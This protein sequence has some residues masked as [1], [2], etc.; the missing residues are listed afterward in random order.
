MR[1]VAVQAEAERK[2]LLLSWRQALQRPTQLLMDGMLEHTSGRALIFIRWEDLRKAPVALVSYRRV[3]RKRIHHTLQ[4]VGQ[5]LFRHA[6]RVC[7]LTTA[8][9]APKRE[10]QL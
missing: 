8:G 3:Q 6:G 10:L 9:L 5:L 2:D 7:Q 1:L 4:Q